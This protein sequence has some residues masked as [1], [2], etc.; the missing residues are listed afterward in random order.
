MT[1][2]AVADI[3]KKQP[4]EARGPIEKR[5]HL[6]E[7]WD[8]DHNN[9]SENEFNEHMRVDRRTFELIVNRISVNIL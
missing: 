9:W 3:V 5:S 6:K 2:Q 1:A 8:S 7:F 4:T